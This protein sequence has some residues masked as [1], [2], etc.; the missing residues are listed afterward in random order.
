M[1]VKNTIK[2]FL[3][4]RNITRYKFS[5]DA[6]IARRTAYDLYDHPEQLPSPDVIRKICDAYEVQPGEL[7][8]WEPG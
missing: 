6:G 8:V 5:Q 7:M 3:D 1:A 2:A 4:E